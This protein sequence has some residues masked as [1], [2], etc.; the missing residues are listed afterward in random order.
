MTPGKLIV[1]EGTDGAGKGT[2]TAMLAE[3]LTFSGVKCAVHDFPRYGMPSAQFVTNYLNGHYG[4]AEEVGAKRASVFYAVDRF[5]AS[6]QIRA[7]IASGKHVVCN[8]YAG[9][10]M[11]HQGGKIPDPEERASYYRWLDEFEFGIMGIPGPDLNLVLHVPAE[12][13]QALVD[14]KEARDYIGGAKRDLH[15][16][17][18]EHLKNA[19]QA[20]LEV[21][22]LFPEQF[23]VV[24][25]YDTSGI[26]SREAIHE[27]IWALVEPLVKSEA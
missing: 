4:T 26:F 27:S 14:Q 17:D 7:Q 8:R 2:Q 18:I 19:E 5:E 1:I 13:A 21:C 16:G 25:C 24:P 3:R 15:E 11:G 9:S 22:G 6:G 12:V 20:F 23:V 10:N